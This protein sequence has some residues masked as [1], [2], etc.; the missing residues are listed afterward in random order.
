[1]QSNNPKTVAGKIYPELAL[2]LV[3]SPLLKTNP[4]FLSA[5]V[6]MKLSPVRRENGQIEV[7]QEPEHQETLVV[8][9]AFSQNDPDFLQALGTIQYAAQ[10][11]I[12]AKNL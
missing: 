7:L 4:D 5:S 3:I 8:S 10:Q 2:S 12:N 11:Y 6:V 1:M 9:D